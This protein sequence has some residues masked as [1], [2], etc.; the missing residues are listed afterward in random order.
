MSTAGF[1]T[2]IKIKEDLGLDWNNPDQV[3]NFEEKLERV[4]KEIYF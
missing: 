2:K 4:T 3:L 1:H